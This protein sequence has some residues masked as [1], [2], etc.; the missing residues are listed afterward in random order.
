MSIVLP[1]ISYIFDPANGEI[2]CGRCDPE[3]HAEM[4]QSYDVR[5]NPVYAL[6]CEAGHVLDMTLHF[7]GEQ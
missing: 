3:G 2:C 7:E 5:G 1:T 6:E 4:R